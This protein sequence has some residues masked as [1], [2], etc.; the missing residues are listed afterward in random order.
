MGRNRKFSVEKLDS[1]MAAAQ[2]MSG[3]V[4]KATRSYHVTYGS[5]IQAAKKLGHPIL[6]LLRKRSPNGTRKQ[7]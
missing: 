5:V 6:G 1:L 3:S 4:V 2:R 7:K